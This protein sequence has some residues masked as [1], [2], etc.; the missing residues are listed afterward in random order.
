MR[1]SVEAGEGH[2]IVLTGVDN[3]GTVYFNDPA[4][5]GP[6]EN[7]VDWADERL[8]VMDGVSIMYLASSR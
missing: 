6:D 7:T 1:C 8:R 2:V 5:E 3:D 4:R